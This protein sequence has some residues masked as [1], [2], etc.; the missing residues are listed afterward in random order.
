MG[1]RQQQVFRFLSADQT[2]QFAAAMSPML[3]SGDTILLAGGLG[4]GKTHFARALISARLAVAGRAEDIPSPT[5]TLV[6]TYDDGLLEL[7]HADLYRLSGPDDMAELGLD[8]A[9]ETAICLIE[10]PDRL[11]GLAP[12]DALTLTFEMTSRPGE[13][14]VTAVYQ[15]AKWSTILERAGVGDA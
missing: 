14:I 7:W 12:A 5:F 11:G 6:Q 4:G 1:N 3:G 2:A 8:Q 10:W 13:R 15:V 9:M